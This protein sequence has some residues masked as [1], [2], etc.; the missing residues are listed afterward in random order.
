MKNPDAMKAAMSRLHE[1]VSGGGG[2]A[3]MM[4]RNGPLKTLMDRAG[5]AEQVAN[6]LKD[7]AMMASVQAMMSNPEA[8][9]RAAE[10]M[11]SQYPET[12]TESNTTVPEGTVVLEDKRK[13]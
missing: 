7:P 1:A 2:L 6:M 12:N 3:G 10:A 8:M 11:K 13:E 5:G 9:K 4:L